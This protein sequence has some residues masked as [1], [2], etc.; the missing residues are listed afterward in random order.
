[1]KKHSAFILAIL[2]VCLAIGGIALALDP[3]TIKPAPATP[4]P[5]VVK[6]KPGI[7]MQSLA[8]RAD[9]DVVELSNGRRVS[10]KALRTLSSL[11]KKMRAAVPG[12]KRPAALKMKPAAKGKLLKTNADLQAALKGPDNETVQLPSGKLVTVGQIKFLQPYV[13]KQ[14]GHKIAVVSGRP[15]LTGSAIRI[16]G[17]EK[18]ADWLEILKKPDSTILESP[19]GTRITLGEL[20]KVMTEGRSVKPAGSQPALTPRKR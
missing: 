11:Q 16:T 20:K 19:E 8:A 2:A 10:V 1:M 4:Q 17:N 15:N 5:M 18:K 13:E 9:T 14:L 3:Q 12:S 6:F 7:T